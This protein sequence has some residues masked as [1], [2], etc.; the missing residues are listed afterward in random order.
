MDCEDSVAAVDVEDKIVAYRNWLGLMKGSLTEVVVK[1]GSQFV[2]SMDSD[3]NFETISGHIGEIKGR[4][5]MLVRNV[6]HLMTTNS[7]LDSSG[8]EIGEGIMDAY[9]TTLCAMHDLK[10]T[11]QNSAC[12]SISVSYTHLRAHETA[13]HLV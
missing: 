13:L 2:R 9:F 6:G 5:L 11:R 12:G 10:G 8:N 3:E 1:N 4:S 7:I